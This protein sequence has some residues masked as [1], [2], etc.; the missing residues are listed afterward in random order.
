[1]VGVPDTVVE[2]GN[3]HG[4][5]NGT[6]SA[7]REWTLESGD[8]GGFHCAKDNILRLRGMHFPLVI[9]NAD[10]N[11]IKGDVTVG[12]TPSSGEMPNYTT[13]LFTDLFSR[14]AFQPGLGILN[15]S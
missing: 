1:M 12:Q 10:V 7:G 2:D 5:W 4:P 15:S 13:D 8:S 3:W 14:C 6:A 9:C 11:L